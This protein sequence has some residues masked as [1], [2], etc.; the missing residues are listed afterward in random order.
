MKH[1]M[2]EGMTVERRAASD[3]E[4]Q[5]D[6]TKRQLFRHRSSSIPIVRITLVFG[7]K[8]TKHPF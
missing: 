4:M 7:L 8:R 3:Y 6:V 1:E 2:H 5:L